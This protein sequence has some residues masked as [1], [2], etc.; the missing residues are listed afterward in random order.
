MLL[1]VSLGLVIGVIPGLGGIAGLSLLMPFLYG[2][3]QISALAMLVGLVAVIPTS[4]TF[5]SV[6]MGIPGST[7][8]QATVLDGFPL[9]RRGEAARALSAAFVSSMMG[10]VFGAVV[11]TGFV[12][13]ARPLVLMFGAPELFMLAVFGLSMVAALAGRSLAKGLA[14]AALGL[15]IGA[16]GG[17]PSTGEFRM[18]FG[19][20]YLYDGVPLVVVALGLFAVPEIA[21]L[22]RGGGAISQS[23]T[24]GKGWRRGVL[25][26]W[27]NLWLSLRCAGM[28]C[29]IGAVPGLGGAVVDWMAYGHAVQTVKAPKSF[30]QGDIRGVIAPE[31]ANNAMQGGAML[32]T[33]LFGIPGSG[34][35][36]VFLAGLVLLGIDPGPGMVTRDLDIT[37]SLIWSLA[38]ANVMGA[39]ICLGLAAPIARLTRI[40]FPLLAPFMMVVMCFAA[41]QATRDI[42]DLLALLALG[43]A[44]ILMKRFGWPRPAVL[45]GFVLASQTETY[46]YQSLQF[47]GWAFLLDP[48]VLVI[49]ALAAASVRVG[50]RNRIDEHGAADP[51]EAP[52]SA[53]AGRR[54]RGP[55]I[56]FALAVAGFLGIG[57]ADAL[58]Q[59][60]L[61]GV[62]PATVT[63]LG[64]AMTGLLLWQL[65]RGG[66]G[67][68]AHLDAEAGG[69]GPPVWGGVAW[70]AALIAGSAL[71]GFFA[72]MLVFLP[73]FLMRRAGTGPVRALAMT[74]VAACAVAGLAAALGLNFPMGWLQAHADLPWPFR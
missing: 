64:L 4:D 32:P 21:D 70:I 25:D 58:G 45:I 67:H 51:Q 33:V 18:T 5:A 29:M 11:L 13:I 10:G 59:S 72:A 49:G 8:S 31:S 68:P 41:F 2:M 3:D 35:M 23:A 28:G 71:A 53:G 6:L 57:L 17:A 20:G 9:A 66:A 37:Y 27:G 47:H 34:A 52:A 12:V 74:A 54:G 56:L 50:L 7:A 65:I 55:Q 30:G 19:T 69:A 46:F 60:F 1:G 22:L 43:V 62:F 61:G 48:G 26:W 73:L 38:I 42:G 15:L 14:A 39:G 24:L 16:M 40:P 44:G 63:L 36:A